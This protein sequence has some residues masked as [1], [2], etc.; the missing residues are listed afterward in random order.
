MVCTGLQVLGYALVRPA[1]EVLFTVVS[2]QEK[3]KA[4]LFVDT[5]VQRLGD[6]AAAAAFEVLDVRLA[7]GPLALAAA[8]L[9]ACAGWARVAAQ[10]GR[11][12]GAL[13][14]SATGTLALPP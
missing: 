9:V 13:A 10:L 5:V 4:K 12:H 6:T 8:A 7:L 14:A 11:R 1:R 2:R 3:Y